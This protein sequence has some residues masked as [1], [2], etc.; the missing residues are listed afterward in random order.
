MDVSSEQEIGKLFLKE[1]IPFNALTYGC[2]GAEVS[3]L[4]S[5]CRGNSPGTAVPN[6]SIQFK[7]P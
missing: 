5:T 4:M 3:S 1:P 2:N 7:T 6:L